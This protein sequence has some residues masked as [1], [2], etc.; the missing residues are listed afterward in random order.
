M[1]EHGEP[2]YVLDAQFRCVL[3]NKAQEK[4]TGIPRGELLGRCIWDVWPTA[5]DPRLKFWD[6]YHRVMRTRVSER[7]EERFAPLDLWVDVQVFPTAEGGLAVFF[8]RI[9]DR[10]QAEA[11]LRESAALLGVI[12]DASSDVIF[13][14]DRAGRFTFANPA[15]LKLIGKPL[16]AVMGHT[17][18]EVLE[19]REVALRLME[20]DRRIME[21][22]EATLVEEAVPLPDGT[23]RIWSS[24][25]T[26]YRDFEGRVVGLLG[27]SRDITE[28]KQ[29]EADRAQLARQRRL[30]LDAARLGWWHYDP[31]DRVATFDEGYRRIFGVQGARR[32]VDELL[33]LIHADDLKRVWAAVEAALDAANPQPYAVEYRIHRPDG[34][35]RW[36][37]A[38]GLPE[39]EGQGSARHAVS[40][41]GTVADI[42]ERKH[43]EEALR[44][45]EA[46]LREADR[47]KNEFLGVLSH[48][49]RNPLAPIRNSVTIM[50]R[51]PAGSPQ[52]RH[53]LQVI[54]R[55]VNQLARLIDDLLDVTRISRGKFRLQ[56]ET[57]ELNS[58]VRSA[59]GDLHSLF[60]RGEIGF[61]VQVPEEPLYVNADRTRLAQIIG[62][63]LQNAA[64]FTPAGGHARLSLA[65]DDDGLAVIE[66]RDNGAGIEPELLDRVFEP[67]LQAEN[68]LDR[69]RGGLGLG[70]ALVKGLVE[71]HGGTVTGLSEG[72]GRGS[73]FVVRLPL[74]E[75]ATA[76][77]PHVDA[78]ATAAAHHILIIEDNQDA[79]LSLKEVLELDGHDVDVAF[80]GVDGLAKAR[81]LCPDV[82]LCDIGLPGLDGYGVARGLRADPR[83][84]RTPLVALSGYAL[85]DDVER[86][87]EAGFD[88]HLA[89]PPDLR[90]LAAILARL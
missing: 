40:F 28:S 68:T 6:V 82:V 63:L 29:A 87:R 23:V 16:A 34:A 39:F 53:A 79:A 26:P 14:K 31:V 52:A 43:A 35:Q 85:P 56:R 51:V 70:L 41:V 38:H 57:I 61:E 77:H 47:R 66:V 69:S 36:V 86:S 9:D 76:P 11:A 60:V 4:T 22:G 10:K 74:H 55:Q 12:S 67:F 30:A 7:F 42:T 32:P 72:V 5:A 24:C 54:D 50:D 27:I 33:K 75:A 71:L 20:T 1:L 83:L 89:K 88:H 15:T 18:A 58:L 46:Q 44:A 48:E 65:R 2:I 45:R 80:D 17:D 3:I 37:E 59:A 84:G 8:H 81:A 49:L 73:T 19:D 21:A 64:K 78:T 13:A 90:A 25:K 62:N